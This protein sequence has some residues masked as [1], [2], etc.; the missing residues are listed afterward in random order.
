MDATQGDEIKSQTGFATYDD[1]LGWTG[2]LADL[3]V[4]RSFAISTAQSS[5]ILHVGDP[6]DPTTP[7]AIVNG[8]NWVGYPGD[9][10]QPVNTAL[11]G[12]VA[13][14]GDVIKSQFGF[15][16]YVASLGS[17]VGTLATV[18]PG[19]GYKLYAADALLSS[20][21]LT[22][23]DPTPA[24]VSRP[25]GPV[26]QTRPAELT[27]ENRPDWRLTEGRQFNMT[28]IAEVELDGFA[29]EETTGVIGA[30]VGDELRGIGSLQHVAGLDATYAFLLVHSNLVGNETVSFRYYDPASDAVLDVIDTLEFSV[31]ASL[32]SLDE[33]LTLRTSSD[34]P[35]LGGTPTAFALSPVSPNPA[36]S[37]MV[38]FQW[39]LPTAERV[40]LRLY[41]VRGRE[42]AT[43][44]N[45]EFAA[46]TYER[47]IDMS[48]L[49]TGMYFYRMQAGTFRDI[50]KF[51][52]I[53]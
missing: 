19:L 5:T 46:G 16:E 13:S 10:S 23:A 20:G 7:I 27:G 2:S 31:D 34:G 1:D 8:W 35:T 30:F 50:Q 32:G 6:V 45:E 3:D 26:A 52:L 29:V 33:P 44:I 51:M 24:P 42:V 38:R 41:D 48:R 25:K 40:S 28:V 18:D 36:R 14:D 9:A 49:A 22:Y 12:Y 4:T 21:W 39:A 15:A 43:L 17:W 11:G 47:S 37:G 53:K